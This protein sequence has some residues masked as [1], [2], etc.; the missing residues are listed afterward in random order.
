MDGRTDVPRGGGG[1]GIEGRRV[2]RAHHVLR[3][4]AR[5]LRLR[6]AP[7]VAAYNNSTGMMASE[8][9]SLCDA[10]RRSAGASLTDTPHR[11]QQAR[12]S[13][14]SRWVCHS[15]PVMSANYS[16]AGRQLAAAAAAALTIGWPKVVHRRRRR[17]EVLPQH[18]DDPDTRM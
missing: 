13:W 16:P 11:R 18:H 1:V 14:W 6:C 8:D 7:E 4:V 2:R 3:E 5:V 10:S 9:R 17:S 15:K 12:T